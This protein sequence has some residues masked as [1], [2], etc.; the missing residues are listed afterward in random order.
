MTFPNC[1]NDNKTGTSKGGALSKAQ[2]AQKF[3][4]RKKGALWAFWKYSFC[5]L[6]KKFEQGHFGDKKFQVV[7]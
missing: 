3:Q 6:F 2:K 7:Q 5:K 1:Y 4:N